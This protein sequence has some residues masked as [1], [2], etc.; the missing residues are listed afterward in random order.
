MWSGQGFRNLLQLFQTQCRTSSGKLQL[1]ASPRGKKELDHIPN[2][3]AFPVVLLR[4]WL[5]FACLEALAGSGILYSP[6]ATKNKDGS[7]DNWLRGT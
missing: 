7:L 4:D 3:P 5:V 1:L 6:G 2:A